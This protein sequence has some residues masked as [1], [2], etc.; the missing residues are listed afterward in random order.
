MKIFQFRTTCLAAVTLF[1]L[2]FLSFAEEANADLVLGS[3][4]NRTLNGV[5]PGTARLTVVPH[6]L[7]RP[8]WPNS[9]FYSGW[10]W[11]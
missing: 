6:F 2:S 4:F 1:L 5:L 9:F 11:P 10:K 7:W 8:K 3:A